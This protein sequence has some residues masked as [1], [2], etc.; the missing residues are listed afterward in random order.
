MAGGSIPNITPAAG[1]PS[2]DSTYSY[3]PKPPNE[4][5]ST[6]S[7]SANATTQPIQEGVNHSSGMRVGCFCTLRPTKDACNGDGSSYPHTHDYKKN[8]ASSGHNN[9][10][11]RNG[12]WAQ[13]GYDSGSWEYFQTNKNADIKL[14]TYDAHHIIPVASVTKVVANHAPI[15][16]IVRLTKWCV[17]NE[18]NMKAIPL[19]GHTICWYVNIY[20]QD[21]AQFADREDN[22]QRAYEMVNSIL[23]HQG[24]NQT[25]TQSI[26][27]ERPPFFNLPQHDY[28]HS[29]GEF[30]YNYLVEVKLKDIVKDVKTQVADHNEEAENLADELYDLSDL[31][32]ED[33]LD[34]HGARDDGTHLNWLLGYY[35]EEKWYR[36]FSMSLVPKKRVFPLRAN[37]S[38]D[39][40][41]KEAWSK[42]EELAKGFVA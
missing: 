36:P 14:I 17:N 29:G 26:Y 27:Q 15:V 3:T 37:Q 13:P 8:A 40:E 6:S 23:K 11:G 41:E 16:Q 19:Y 34:E 33:I 7:R 28:G 9:T 31:V 35:G 1:E 5:G 22:M 30:D 20:N 2:L 24:V 42:L 4:D 18:R 32:S 10:G 39:K 21:L 12:N 25:N 38:G